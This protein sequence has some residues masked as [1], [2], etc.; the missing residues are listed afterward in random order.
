ME[1]DLL[2][3]PDLRWFEGHFPDQPIL[4]GAAQLHIASVLAERVWGIEFPGH[5]MS[6]VKFRRVM[7]P[8]ERVS[9]RLSAANGGWTS[10]M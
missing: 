5:D 3:Q 2:L 8:G 7:Q 9:P 10:S 4:P 6:R 1:F